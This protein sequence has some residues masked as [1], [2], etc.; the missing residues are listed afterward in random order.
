MALVDRPTSWA[1]V[2]PPPP[3]G[4]A[5][6]RAGDDGPLP[7]WFDALDTAF[8]QVRGAEARYHDAVERRN[9]AVW[10]AVRTKRT[11]LAWLGNILGVSH[12]RIAQYVSQGQRLAAERG[13]SV[14]TVA[15]RVYGR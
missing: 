8:A 5:R 12:Q 4:T 6:T 3:L 10:A 9:L 7:G 13:L 1:E 15:E 2:A 14:E 11:S